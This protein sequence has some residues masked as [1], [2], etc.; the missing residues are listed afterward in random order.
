VLGPFDHHEVL[1]V[2]VTCLEDERGA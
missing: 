2:A 1:S